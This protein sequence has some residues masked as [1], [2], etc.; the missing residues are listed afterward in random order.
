MGIV[1]VPINSLLT[2]SEVDYLLEDSGALALFTDRPVDVPP[3]VRSVVSFG[4]AYERS[5]HE[6]KP[7]NIADVTLGKP[8]HYTSGTTGRPKGVWVSPQGQDKAA[9]TSEC[10]PAPLGSH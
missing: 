4:D 7:I 9:T 3:G 6:A 5:L 8:M 1:P 10:F 2:R